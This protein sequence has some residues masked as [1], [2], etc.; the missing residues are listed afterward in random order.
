MYVE[1]Y[2]RVAVSCQL[3]CVSVIA[4]GND[5]ARVDI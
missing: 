1:I 3:V 5:L 4:N 2:I